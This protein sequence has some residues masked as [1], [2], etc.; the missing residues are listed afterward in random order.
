MCRESD[1]WQAIRFSKELMNLWQDNL[2]LF[3]KAPGSRKNHQAYP[4]GYIA[5]VADCI[6]FGRDMYGVWADKI[7]DGLHEEEYFALQDVT[8]VM[9]LHDLEKPW[10][11]V[12]D[13]LSQDE[14]G[15]LLQD[16]AA[17]KEFRL[18]KIVEYN[19]VLTEEQRVALDQ[20]EG[21]RDKDYSPN[22]RGFTPLGAFCHMCDLAS[23]RI[24]Y[25]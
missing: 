2:E 21:I 9:F 19:I 6:K 15:K 8:M 7:Y 16:K 3:R 18:A 25:T 5:H 13:A 20:V 10:L 22:N 17:R 14:K 24:F 12:E 1:I 11:Y 4:G 23:S